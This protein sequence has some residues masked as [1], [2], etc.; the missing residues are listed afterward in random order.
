VEMEGNVRAPREAVNLAERQL[1]RAAVQVQGTSPEGDLYAHTL[2]GPDVGA[3]LVLLPQ[4][5][6]P[7]HS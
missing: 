6:F 4:H 2:F 5:P 3:N 7:S 1:D